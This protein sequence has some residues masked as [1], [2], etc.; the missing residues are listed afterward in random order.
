MTT[1]EILGATIEFVRTH[2][3]PEQSPYR[4]RLVD[5]CLEAF[6]R[7]GPTAEVIVDTYAIGT[8]TRPQ[9]LY[10]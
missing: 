10:T 9:N 7:G 1:D 6:E 4:E 3:Y 2:G 5:L 8:T